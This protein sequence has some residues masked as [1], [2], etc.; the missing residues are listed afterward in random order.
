M[1]LIIDNLAVQKT[2]AA[3]IDGRARLPVFF[4]TAWR[5]MFQLAAEADVSCYWVPAHGRHEEWNAP[6]GFSTEQCRL[7]NEGA[8]I[9]ASFAA[10]TLWE[11]YEND[12]RD[13]ERAEARAHGALMRMMSGSTTLLERVKR[14]DENGQNFCSGYT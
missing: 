11:V 14:L 6:P 3:A 2:I 7:L 12:V 5:V 1:I 9:G 10:K 8:Y 13:A 4:S